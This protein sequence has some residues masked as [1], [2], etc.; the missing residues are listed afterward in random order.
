M[1]MQLL[2]FF[3]IF[4]VFFIILIIIAAKIDDY[5]SEKRWN[6]IIKA[7]SAFKSRTNDSTNDQSN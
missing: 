2:I 1:N 7:I 5:Y 4:F 6:R 3:L